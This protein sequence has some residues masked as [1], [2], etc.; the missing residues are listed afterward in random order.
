M[1]EDHT[2]IPLENIEKG[3]A[4]KDKKIKQLDIN[5]IVR[6]QNGYSCF[7]RNKIACQIYF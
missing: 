2:R 3:T 7:L 5:I 6:Y 1:N 4:P